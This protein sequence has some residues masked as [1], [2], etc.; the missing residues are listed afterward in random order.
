MIRCSSD[1][2][3]VVPVATAPGPGFSSGFEDRACG[4]TERRVC[5]LRDVGLKG[6]PELLVSQDLVP[7]SPGDDELARGDV[8]LQAGM[9]SLLESDLDL[10][11]A[12]D[13]VQ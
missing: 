7:L 13:L 9:R 8:F 2:D 10:A 3:I 11:F 5:G 6:G 1:S 12:A 4:L